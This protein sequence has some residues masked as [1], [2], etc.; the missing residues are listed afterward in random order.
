MKSLLFASLIVSFLSTGCSHYY[1]SQSDLNQR[2]DSWLKNREF[3]KIEKALEHLS[4]EHS[5]YNRI[6]ARASK[7]ETEKQNYIKFTLAAASKF[8]QQDKWQKAIDTLNEALDKIPEDKKLLEK[9]DSLIDERNHQVAQLR[10]SM[11]LKKARAL[12]QYKTIYNKL[13]KLIPKDFSAQYDINKYNRE[14]DEISEQLMSCGRHALT[15]RQYAQAEECFRL[16][17]NLTPSKGKLALLNKTQKKRKLI[18][19]ENKSKILIG[20]YQKAIEAGDFPKAR[21]QL[22]ALLTLNPGYKQ[23]QQL[24]ERLDKKIS[25][26]MTKGIEEGKKYYSEGDI[27]RAVIIWEELLKIEPENEELISLINRG[28]KVSKKIEKLEKSSAN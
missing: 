7:I 21:D 22:K 20:T 4:A 16:S 25:A 15:E 23:A 11:L 24:K 28:K 18:D 5:D 8:Q 6:K 14:K 10:K 26:R 13:E 19:Q 3:S 9:R 12:I 1:A 2:I 17:N 27:N